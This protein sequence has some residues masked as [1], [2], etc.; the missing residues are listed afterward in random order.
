MGLFVFFDDQ[1]L[2]V[3]VPL[4][5]L[6]GSSNFKYVLAFWYKG[7]QD[8]LVFFLFQTWNQPFL[9]GDLVTFTRE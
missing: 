3:F 1:M 7:F 8:C 5:Q 9:L 4:G 2:P 6:L